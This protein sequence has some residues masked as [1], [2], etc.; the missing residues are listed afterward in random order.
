M[1]SELAVFIRTADCWTQTGKWVAAATTQ[2][3]LPPMM[4]M[5]LE[6]A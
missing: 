5:P 4:E 3:R 6:L 2:G 1:E